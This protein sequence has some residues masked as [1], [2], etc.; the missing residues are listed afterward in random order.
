MTS[1]GWNSAK[2]RR[3][4]SIMMDYVISRMRDQNADDSSDDDSDDF[5][6]SSEDMQSC[7]DSEGST[8]SSFSSIG[9]TINQL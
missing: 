8:A 2:K 3:V 9:A 1:R 6:D 7:T 4:F 5:S